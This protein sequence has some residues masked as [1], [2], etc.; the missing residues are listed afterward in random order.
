M[1]Q[2]IYW[3][4]KLWRAR[5]C[6]GKLWF[7]WEFLL[8][9]I[10]CHHQALFTINSCAGFYLSTDQP[11]LLI[12]EWLNC[13]DGGK[14][15][16]WRTRLRILRDLICC[17]IPLTGGHDKGT[18]LTQETW[19][20]LPIISGECVLEGLSSCHKKTSNS[21]WWNS[22]HTIQIVPFLTHSHW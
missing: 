14:W 3:V 8:H 11:F 5:E 7:L 1:R 18:Y 4:I 13:S 19:L 6:W 10:I 21:T 22:S 15:M 9:Q 12:L 16:Q 17:N 20:T 2:V